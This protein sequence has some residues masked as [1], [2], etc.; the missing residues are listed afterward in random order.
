MGDLRIDEFHQGTAVY[1]DGLVDVSRLFVGE[2]GADS[3]EAV[4]DLAQTIL[5]RGDPRLAVPPDVL[6][7]VLAMAVRRL[8]AHDET[9]G[10]Q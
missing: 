7:Y 1:L 9:G 4:R 6:A 5:G 8:A 2:A 3:P 10:G